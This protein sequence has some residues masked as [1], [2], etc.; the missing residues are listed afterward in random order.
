MNR[1]GTMAGTLGEPGKYLAARISPDG[2]QI[3]TVQREALEL[4]KSIWVVDLDRNVDSR[5]TNLGEADDPVWSPDGKRLAF[6]WHKGG[7]DRANLFASS[8]ERPE[9]PEALMP[10]GS[11]R[12]PL[13]WSRD[14]RFV[15]FAQ[16]DAVSKYDLWILPLAAGGVPT[17]VVQ[18]PGKDNEARF[19]PDGR[20]I[21]F[22]S[23]QVVETRV[24][25]RALQG[26]REQIPVSEGHGAEPRW[27]GDGTELYYISG[28][29]A[30]MAVPIM[31]TG[32][33]FTA[34]RPTRLFGGKNTGSR[35]V[36]FDVAPDGRRFLA[37]MADEGVEAMAVRLLLD[38]HPPR[39]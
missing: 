5:I 11:V 2:K 28:D 27:R 25:V 30:L 36:H 1:D 23:D 21:A 8:L 4:G 10:A 35:L 19:S 24:Y 22:Q 18:T 6:A 20:L 14:G 12:W 9:E 7:E 33:N 37:L 17:L 26:R 29:G 31:I 16:V 39:E 15:I 13:D 3:A 34:G 32:E 38:W